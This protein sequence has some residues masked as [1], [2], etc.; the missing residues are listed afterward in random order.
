MCI[1]D[2]FSSSSRH[3]DGLLGQKSSSIPTILFWSSGK[4]VG[5]WSLVSVEGVAIVW[6]C[7]YVYH[8]M[9][10]DNETSW[11]SAEGR[12]PSIHAAVSVRL[13]QP[14]VL[15]RVVSHR[16]GAGSERK[17]RAICSANQ[18]TFLPTLSLPLRV[19]PPRSLPTVRMELCSLAAV[20]PIVG[21]SAS[22]NF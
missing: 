11:S 18:C 19:V 9:G 6:V 12:A 20:A 1:R 3:T 16:S 22:S 14:A 17:T 4:Y 10:I 5:A 13:G 8:S 7:S 21:D 15:G 2:S